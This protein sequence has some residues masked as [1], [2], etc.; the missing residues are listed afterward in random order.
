M[1][2][3]IKKLYRLS[4]G[5]KKHDCHHITVFIHDKEAYHRGFTFG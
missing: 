5:V 3:I 4:L 2:M 1:K